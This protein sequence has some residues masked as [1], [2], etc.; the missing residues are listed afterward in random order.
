M[1]DLIYNLGTLTLTVAD[2]QEISQGILNGSPAGTG[3]LTVYAQAP[4]SIG[5]ISNFQNARMHLDG[6]IHV[7]SKTGGSAFKNDNTSPDAITFGD[8]ARIHLQANALCTY[9]SG[10][11][12]LDFDTAPTDGRTLSVTPA[13]D[14]EPA[15]TFATDGTCWGYAFLAAA[16]T[17]YTAS[18]DG[19]PAI[20]RQALQRVFL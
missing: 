16:D 9:V 8:N 20:C 17:R 19:E 2:A 15:A 10:F 4:L 5:A 7:I 14:D 11:I 12:E 1:S 13:G 6:E 3:T 18:L